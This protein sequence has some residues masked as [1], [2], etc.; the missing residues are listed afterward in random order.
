VWRGSGS[1]SS[2]EARR[3]RRGLKA[4]PQPLHRQPRAIRSRSAPRPGLCFARS[5][6]VGSTW[7]HDPFRW[8][9]LAKRDGARDTEPRNG[10][11]GVGWVGRMLRVIDLLRGP[12]AGCHSGSCFCSIDAPRSG[13]CIA[14]FASLGGV[15]Q[16]ARSGTAA[17]RVVKSCFAVDADGTP[18]RG[19]WRIGGLSAGSAERDRV[20]RPERPD[21]NAIHA[22]RPGERDSAGDRACIGPP[23]GRSVS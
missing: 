5:A 20:A 12:A 19:V 8:R 22:E 14:T 1:C 15:A 7:G 18:R 13:S 2:P 21:C 11:V 3:P 17:W 23:D 10:N 6:G 4:G 9:A 16:L